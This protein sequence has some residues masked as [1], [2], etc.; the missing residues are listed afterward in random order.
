MDSPTEVECPKVFVL[1]H[2]TWGRLPWRDAEWCEPGSALRNALTAYEP[3]AEFN[4]LNWGGGN[5]TSSRLA[6][7]SLLRKRLGE[8][9]ASF[10]VGAEI[11]IVAHSHA[12]N[13]AMLVLRDPQASAQVVRLVCLST[14]FIHVTPR[15]LG[16]RLAKFVTRGTAAGL[17]VLSVGLIFGAIAV[18]GHAAAPALLLL[19]PVAV[20]LA[21]FVYPKRIRRAHA[22]NHRLAEKLQLP[23]RLSMRVLMVR[24][25]ADEAGNAFGLPQLASQVLAWLLRLLQAAFDHKSKL[26]F[27]L[28]ATLYPLTIVGVILT[29]LLMRRLG[30]EMPSSWAEVAMAVAVSVAFATGI[31]VLLAPLAT[32]VILMLCG[33]CML[34]YGWSAFLGAVSLHVSA[35]ATPPGSWEVFQLQYTGADGPAGMNHSTHS[36]PKAIEAVIAWMGR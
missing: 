7:A 25:V 32:F 5:S 22:S 18:V 11:T 17:C 10:G 4:V 30:H 15:V 36:H 8:L 24:N 26:V 29:S 6:G 3:C 35:E 2:G 27:I 12:G 28:G 19:L 23:S 1:V 9:R 31:A 14:P 13:V 16:E 33:V 20:L 34:P 21:F